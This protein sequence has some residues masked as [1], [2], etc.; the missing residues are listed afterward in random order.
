MITINELV[1]EG[2]GP[3]QSCSKILKR[4]SISNFDNIDFDIDVEMEEDIDIDS[5]IDIEKNLRF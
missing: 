3:R 1:A 5:N 2:R 4:S